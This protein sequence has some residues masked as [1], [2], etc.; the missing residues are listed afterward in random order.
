MKIIYLLLLFRITKIVFL[1]TENRD[2]LSTQLSGA[3]GAD[4][5]IAKLVVKE[6]PDGAVLPQGWGACPLLW[7]SC[8]LGQ[9]GRTWAATQER[10]ATPF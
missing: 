1:E 6:I 2:A 7:S 10:S 8:Q 3:S 9:I 4:I 5:E